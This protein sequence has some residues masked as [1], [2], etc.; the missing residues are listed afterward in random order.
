MPMTDRSRLGMTSAK[1]GGVP[2]PQASHSLAKARLGEECLAGGGGAG[3]S[4]GAN[5]RCG[6]GGACARGPQ[7]VVKVAEVKTLKTN[8]H[9]TA[10]IQK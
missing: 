3:G 10:R 1:S 8:A 5:P 2:L 6:L 4:L 7:M 9:L